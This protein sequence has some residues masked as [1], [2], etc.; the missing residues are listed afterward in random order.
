MSCVVPHVSCLAPHIVLSFFSYCFYFILY[1]NVLH[2]SIDFFMC[3]VVCCFT[4]RFFPSFFSG[5]NCS[6]S[7]SQWNVV[8]LVSFVYAWWVRLGIGEQKHCNWLL[9]FIRWAMCEMWLHWI[10]TIIEAT[11]KLKKLFY[12]FL[13]QIIFS[14]ADINFYPNRHECGN[15]IPHFLHDNF[16]FFN[17][18]NIL[19]KTIIHIASI[20]P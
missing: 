7:V 8:T 2:W 17:F 10:Q 12:N 14:R 5:I 6:G 3:S 15:Q 13:R 4:F 1:S 16:F 20:F 19:N 18:L 11:I 9:L